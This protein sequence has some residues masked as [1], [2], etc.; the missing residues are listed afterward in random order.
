M[1]ANPVTVSTVT[2]SNE[3][4]YMG[5]PVLHYTINF[6]Q[7]SSDHFSKAI[8]KMNRYHKDRAWSYAIYISTVLARNAVADYQYNTEHG[9][10]IRE[11]EAMMHFKVTLNQDCAVSLY[12]DQYEYTGGAHGSTVRTSNTWNLQTAKQIPLKALFPGN[13]HYAAD[14]KAAINQQIARQIAD[15]TGFYFDNYPQLVAQ[16]F[17]PKSY[18]LTP[19]HLNLY[20]QQYDI[21]PYAS[22]LPVFALPFDS[23]GATPPTCR[24][25]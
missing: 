25:I 4:I 12:T 13:I 23:V 9:Y 19:G 22:G 2:L 24:Q 11:Y 18:Y 5:T 15:G 6:P 21:A 10:P 8:S 20:F 14:L 16:T 3:L 1:F 7:F 17:N